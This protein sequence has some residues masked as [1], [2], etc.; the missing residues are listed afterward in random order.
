MAS[1]GSY[2]NCDTL[3]GE[4]KTQK[5]KADMYGALPNDFPAYSRGFGNSGMGNYPIGIWTY[6]TL[7]K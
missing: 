5:E 4:L 6:R 7:M 2:D 1:K 3:I